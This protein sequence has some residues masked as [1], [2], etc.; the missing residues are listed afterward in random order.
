M[1][2]FKG[3]SSLKQFMPKK[4]VK[5]GYKVWSLADSEGYLY[6][7]DIY[8]GKTKDYVEHLLGEKVVLRLTQGLEN[9][10]HFLFFDNFFNTYS[11][12]KLLKEKGLYSCGTVNANRKLLPKNMLDDRK[13]VQG[14][15]DFRVSND[16]ITYIKWKD[17]RVVHLLSNYSNPKSNTTVNRKQK[18]G[19]TIPIP[20]PLAL[21][22]YNKNMNFVDRFDQMKSCYEL[23][24][25]SKK[26]WH[27]IFFHFVDCCVVNAF[28]LYKLKC[29]AK[30]IT[31]LTQKNF[32]R[33][34][35][36]GLL[37]QRIVELRGK[38]MSGTEEPS[39]KKRKVPEEVRFESA[40]HQPMRSSRRRCARCSTRS[41]QVRTEWCCST[42]EVPLCLGKN[43]TCFQDFHKK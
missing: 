39:K 4:P 2:K 33:R 17:K 19:T 29:Q 34:I 38:K 5:W 21:V 28:I 8:T 18:D 11:L 43:K 16:G 27:R 42:C 37:A 3:R 25:K 7:F 20:C 14:Q 9:K 6:N 23:D 26:W 30:N 13:M 12:Q 32:K 40:S 31:S 10:G 36:D 41:E 35:I 24:R 15:F 1:I 22:D